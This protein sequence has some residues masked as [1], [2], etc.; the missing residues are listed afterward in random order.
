GAIP[1]RTVMTDSLQ[2]LGYVEAEAAA[3]NLLL[4]KGQVARGHEFHYSVLKDFDDSR[5]AYRLTG[6]KGQDRRPEGYSRDNL[7]ASYV[8]LHFGCRP[9]LAV[10]LLKRCRNYRRKEG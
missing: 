3:D 8:H 1:A 4:T 6:G 10:E 7:L 5:P 9:Q 2:A